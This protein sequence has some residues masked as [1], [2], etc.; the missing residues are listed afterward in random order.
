MRAFKTAST[1]PNNYKI[2]VLLN[3]LNLDFD[4]SKLKDIDDV[5]IPLKYF[6]NRKYDNILK[7]N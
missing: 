3:L 1:K 5:Y 2:T 4:Y 7:N 6:T